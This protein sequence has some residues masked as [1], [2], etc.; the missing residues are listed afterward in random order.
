MRQDTKFHCL[1]FPEVHHERT[2]S[3][4]IVFRDKIRSM[5]VRSGEEHETGDELRNRNL[6][7]RTVMDFVDV[8]SQSTAEI[9]YLHLAAKSS[10]RGRFLKGYAFNADEYREIAKND[11]LVDPIVR[12][13]AN[14]Q[15]ES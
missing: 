7:S 12:L 10:M 13:N 14:L 3:Y 15:K 1:A 4:K 9:N 5:A 11:G 8:L 2:C 6:W